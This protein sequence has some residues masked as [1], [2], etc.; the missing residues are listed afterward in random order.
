MELTI[1][2]PEDVRHILEQRAK[3]YGLDVKSFVESLV[4]ASATRSVDEL[5]APAPANDAEFEADMQAFAE[6]TEH[7][8]AYSGSYSRADIYFDHD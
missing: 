3:A 2:V 5:S 7:L 6:G 1:S 4:Q 8:P